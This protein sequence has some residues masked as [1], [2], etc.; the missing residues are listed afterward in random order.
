[1]QAPQPITALH[2]QRRTHVRLPR[3][4]LLPL[5]PL[6]ALRLLPQPLPLLQLVQDTLRSFLDDAAVVPRQTPS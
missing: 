1:L 6:L 5:L 3:L 2:Q 4:P